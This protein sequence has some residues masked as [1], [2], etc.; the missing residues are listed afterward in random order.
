MLPV[1]NKFKPPLPGHINTGDSIINV[2]NVRLHFL[3]LNLPTQNIAEI[4]AS[5]QD[6]NKN[7]NAEA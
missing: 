2:V 3:H 5:S 6:V 7:G 4:P 1:W